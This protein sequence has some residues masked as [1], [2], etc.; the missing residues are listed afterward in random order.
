MKLDAADSRFFERQLEEIEAEMVTIE[1]PDMKARTLI[2]TVFVDEGANAITYRQLDKVGEAKIVSPNAKDLPRV[3]VFGD[4]ATKYMRHIGDSFGYTRQEVANAR[5]AN[6]AL[7]RERA[8]AAREILLRKEDEIS[9][10]GSSADGLEGLCKHSAATASN[11]PN[12][13]SAS[14]LWAN[15]TAA[16]ILAD[17][18]YLAK[19]VRDDTL[20]IHSADSMLMPEDSFTLI[21]QTPWATTGLSSDTILSFF[22][23][24][25]PF[26]KAIEPWHHLATAGA[27]SGR[28]LMVYKRDRK[29]VKQHLVDYV[30]LAPQ[31]QGLEE[32]VNCY[33][34]HG[35]VTLYYPKTVRY[36]DGI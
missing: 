24:T 29:F 23:K 14:P 25:N 31:A 28:R 32:V 7:D 4:E 13:A 17:M 21:A 6:V 20:G 8:E 35:G 18:N 26:I 1:R 30:Q 5:K 33:S 11:A 19:A 22:L 10:I 34:K 36:L 16:E 15:K 2:P 12:G 9:A 27:S 3:D